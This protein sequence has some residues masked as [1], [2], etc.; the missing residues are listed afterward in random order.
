ML[1]ANNFFMFLI[2][3]YGAHTAVTLS[4]ANIILQAYLMLMNTYGE[5]IE[6]L[7][8]IN[9]T[10]SHQGDLSKPHLIIFWVLSSGS[11]VASLLC[12]NIC[13]KLYKSLTDHVSYHQPEVM[14][15]KLHDFVLAGKAF[16]V[17]RKIDG[18][19]QSHV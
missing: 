4:V 2:V 10:K 19:D 3:T 15:F 8:R 16:L 18:Y 13:R 5:K 12:I 14:L 11:I 7:K 17:S 9:V 6:F 1:A